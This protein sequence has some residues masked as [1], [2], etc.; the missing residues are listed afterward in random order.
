MKGLFQTKGLDL[1]VKDIDAKTRR[2][3][4]ALSRF[5]NV[6]SDGDV[7][8]RGAF[9]KSIQERGHESQGNRK[10]KF[11]RYHDFEHEIGKWISLEESSDYL[12]G[13][14]EL[15]RSTKGNDALLD[16]QD[17]IITEHSIGF[18]S[19]PD[20]TF[21]RED[22][23]TELR[24][25]FLM[26]GSAVTFGANQDTPVLDVSKSENRKEYL[27]KLNEKMFN[28]IN[29]LKNGKGTDDR[30]ETFENQLRV[31]QSKYNSLINLEPIMNHSKE[32]EPN[33]NNHKQFYLNLI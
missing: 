25:V 5:G 17:G 23:I 24:E 20:K 29:A 32:D 1:E 30:L 11:L 27:D 7:I 2:V 12:I 10:I 16:Y 19:I 9:A 28:L 26:E 3:K 6:D 15:G 14:G 13:I 33:D 21:L 31:L 22:G 18:I 4:V 8:T